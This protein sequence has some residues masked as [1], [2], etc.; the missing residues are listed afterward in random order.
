MTAPVCTRNGKPKS[1]FLYGALPYLL[2]FV[3]LLAILGQAGSHDTESLG[4][5]RGMGIAYALCGYTTANMGHQPSRIGGIA[6]IALS[7]WIVAAQ[8]WYY[9][10]F[11]ELFRFAARP[12]LRRLWH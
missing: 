9:F 2:C 6:Q 4:V 7:V 8:A 3:P 11:L 1:D 12:I 10:K 5:L